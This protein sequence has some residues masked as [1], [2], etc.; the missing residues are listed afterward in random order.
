MINMQVVGGYVTGLDFVAVKGGYEINVPAAENP[1][2]Q[3]LALEQEAEQKYESWISSVSDENKLS[4]YQ[5]RSDTGAILDPRMLRLDDADR[6][7]IKGISEATGFSRTTVQTFYALSLQSGLAK[8]MKDFVSKMV[9]EPT[10]TYNHLKNRLSDDE[11][12]KILSTMA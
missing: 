11:G 4:K 9:G 5:Y 1:G 10:Q 2:E 6:A 7:G 12:A 8:D 3:L